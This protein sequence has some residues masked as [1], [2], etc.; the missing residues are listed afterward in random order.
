MNFNKY[1][2]LFLKKVDYLDSLK[3]NKYNLKY[4]NE[5]YFDMIFLMLNN[6]NTWFSLTYTKKYGCKRKIYKNHYR[7]INNKFNKWTK[8]CVF[9]QIFNEITLKF[10]ENTNNFLIDATSIYNKNG[11]ECISY[12]PENYKKKVTK[13]SMLT[14]T[15]GFIIDVQQFKMNREKED[16]NKNKKPYKTFVHDVKMINDHLNSNNFK[17]IKNNSKYLKI[18]GD[19]AYKHKNIQ[20]NNK[21]CIMVTPDKKNTLNKNSKHNNKKLKKRIKVE[22]N[23]LSLKKY[24]R[25]ILRKDKNINVF[26]SWVYIISSTFNLNF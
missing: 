4:S 2:Q 14:R 11:S 6:V 5:Y 21:I 26:M 24:E 20:I 1:K 22:H 19:K 7:T 13:I 15:D 23:F 18:I 16:K 17:N 10:N 12:N 3:K 9:I 25:L 8:E